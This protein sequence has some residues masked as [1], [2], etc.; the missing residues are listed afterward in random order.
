MKWGFPKFLGRG[1]IILVIAII[2]FGLIVPAYCQTQDIVLLL[3]QTPVKGG[4]ITPIAGVHHFKP[5][6]EVMLTAVAKPGYKFIHWLGEVSDA[7]ASSTVAYLNKPKVIIA[8]FEQAKHGIS[9]GGDGLSAGGGGAPGGLFPT[10]L[11]LSRPG[12]FSGGGGGKA[13]PQKYIYIKDNKPTPEVPEPATGLLLVLGSL[14][15]FKRR[16]LKKACRINNCR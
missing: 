1:R 3:E 13:K 14:F 11:D 16:G 9:A 15:A 10:A 7:T 12:G 5:G 4:E 6:T 2:A 8:V